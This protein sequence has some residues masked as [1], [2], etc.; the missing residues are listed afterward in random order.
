MEFAVHSLEH[1]AVVVWYR[2]DLESSLL[3]DLQTFIGQW[4]S[5]VIVA[6]NPGIT[7]PIVATAWARLQRFEEVGVGL[8]E[9]ADVYRKRGP[10]SIRCDI[11]SI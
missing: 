1:G 5:H 7:E 8:S 4:D 10:E 2:S 6:A 9:F 3:A 11:E